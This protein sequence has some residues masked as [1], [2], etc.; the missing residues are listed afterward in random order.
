MFSDIFLKNGHEKRLKYP[1][2]GFAFIQSYLS[3]PSLGRMC[4][5][6]KV[7]NEIHFFTR[8]YIRAYVA[9]DNFCLNYSFN[10]FTTANIKQLN[11]K[12]FYCILLLLSDDIS[13]NPGPKNNLQP[14]DS[15][16]WNVFKSKGL[17]LIHLNIN[18]FLS[19]ID[20]L[21]YIANSSNAAVI[22]ISESKLDKSLLQLEIQI[23]N[24]DLLRRDRNRNGGRVPCY[25]RNDISYNQ[26]QY[27][28]EEI[29]NIFFEILLPK[30]KPIVVGI[31]YRSPTQNNFLELLNKNFPSIDTDAK[32]TY[33]L[34][35]F[36]IN[37]YE[38]NKYIVHENNT[39]CRKFASA[40]A[41]KYHQF[42]TM[43]GL[44]QL[45][46]CPTR[47]TCSTST[48]INHI[49]GSF[50]SRVS[51]KGVIN[52]GFSDHQLIFCTRKVSKFKTG[53]VHKYINFRSL[54]NYRV[55]DYKKSLG[56]L[57]QTVKF[58]TTSMRRIQI[59]FRKS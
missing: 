26:K 20:A 9:L 5:K 31:I 53:S 15:N 13:L 22:G 56:Q 3:S 17:H 57:A 29:E 18:S 52:V 54:K 6:V 11:N 24:Y 42:C 12:P 38:N 35:D 14:L 28:P 37:M 47:V 21:R 43:H 44:K 25:I 45:T 33:I 2:L 23:N 49:L 41:K 59:S 58:P 16:E 4:T 32:E 1:L 30:I 8:L 46:Q 51:R 50:P 34:G 10:M 40:D 7:C 27:F 36:N 55:D 48:L 39:V 19:K